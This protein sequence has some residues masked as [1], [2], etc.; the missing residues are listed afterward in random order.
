MSLIFF[1]FW[2]LVLNLCWRK[3]ILSFLAGML[4]SSNCELIG[5]EHFFLLSVFC[6]YINWRMNIENGN[7][8]WMLWN[9]ILYDC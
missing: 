2:P 9:F 3:G 6:S 7:E 1:F 4:L 8:K 5:D